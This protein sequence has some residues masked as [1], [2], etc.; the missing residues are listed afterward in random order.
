MRQCH[1]RLQEKETQVFSSSSCPSLKEF[2][3]S[4]SDLCLPA[5]TTG[6]RAAAQ[7]H[8][9]IGISFFLLVVFLFLFNHLGPAFVVLRRRRRANWYTHTHTHRH[10][11]IFFFFFSGVEFGIICVFISQLWISPSSFELVG[12]YRRR[13]P[14]AWRLFAMTVG[15][16]W[17]FFFSSFHFPSLLYSTLECYERRRKMRKQTAKINLPDPI[18]NSSIVTSS[19]IFLYSH[20]FSFSLSLSKRWFT[21]YVVV[22]RG[23]HCF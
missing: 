3:N 21:V 9:S 6:G 5:P 15:L 17:V 2:K 19:V 13:V 7:E 23:G 1:H 4:C 8:R 10:F 11:L 18:L 12:I 14:Y 22:C 20:F 16:F